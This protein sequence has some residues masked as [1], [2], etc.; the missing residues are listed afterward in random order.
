M[1]MTQLVANNKGLNDD[2]FFSNSFK[3]FIMAQL[4]QM[5]A[6]NPNFDLPTYNSNDHNL[7]NAHLFVPNQAV[8]LAPWLKITLSSIQGPFQ[9]LNQLLFKLKS[10]VDFALSTKVY[11]E[12]QVKASEERVIYFYDQCGVIKRVLREIRLVF[13]CRYYFCVH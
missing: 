8:I 6:P 13:F 12:H 9:N 2:S 11:A 3:S 10:Y 1:M 5:G 7:F 4:T